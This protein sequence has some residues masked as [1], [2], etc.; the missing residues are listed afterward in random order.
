[1]EGDEDSITL[2]MDEYARLQNDM[3]VVKHENARIKEASEKHLEET[4]LQMQTAQ[5]EIMRLRALVEENSSRKIPKFSRE[6]VV[7]CLKSV[8]KHE[9]LDKEQTLLMEQIF[10]IIEYIW[11]KGGEAELKASEI[12]DPGATIENKLLK[13]SNTKIKFSLE[14]VEEKCRVMATSLEE[15]AK[16]NLKMAQKISELE[17]QKE[18]LIMDLASREEELG[19]A[20]IALKEKYALECSKHELELQI[21]N[22][23]N[24]IEKAKAETKIVPDKHVESERSGVLEQALEEMKKN[25]DLLSLEYN[26][27]KNSAKQTMHELA[28][29]KIMIKE[30]ENLIKKNE[31][32]LK[33]MQVELEDMKTERQIIQKRSMHDLKDLK[34]ELVKEKNLHEQCKMD[35]EKVIQENRKLTENMRAGVKIAPPT[36]QEK[37][38]VESMSNR[39]SELEHANY[40]LKLKIQEICGLSTA[41]EE[42][43]KENEELKNEIN[44]LQLDIAMMG[45]QFNDYVRKSNSLHN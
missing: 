25:E 33:K 18:L 42:L 1:M 10:A 21:E 32:Q 5:A 41:N 45:A 11:P 44:K 15:T 20:R 13:E 29:A 7:G 3:L 4:A 35:K 9:E 17:T 38:L 14:A 31:E 28:N 37:I 27:L 23:K 39:V 19:Q 40:A 16:E 2:S 34:A 24:T 12:G 6:V 30:H 36:H 22:M 8:R 26:N 43:E